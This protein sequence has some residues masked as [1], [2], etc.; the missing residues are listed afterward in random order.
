MLQ[1]LNCLLVL[2][3]GILALILQPTGA[4]QVEHSG[5]MSSHNTLEERPELTR[6]AFKSA[7]KKPNE[8]KLSFEVDNIL[9]ERF[10]VKLGTAQNKTFRLDATNTAR[11][12]GLTSDGT[13]TVEV[14]LHDFHNLVMS[15]VE[16]VPDVLFA[17]KGILV[18]IHHH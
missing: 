14:Q 6:Q 3:L 7:R 17:A 15:S 2:L 16:L 18:P 12:V 9:I 4:L 10:R 11:I 8:E 1:L 13:L 5:E